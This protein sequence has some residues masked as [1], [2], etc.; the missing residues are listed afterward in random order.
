MTA[1]SSLYS[2]ILLFSVVCVAEVISLS[3]RSPFASNQ[4]DVPERNNVR[5]IGSS[6]SAFSNLQLL[7]IVLIASVD[8]KIRA[9][10][11]GSGQSLW[12]MS[13]PSTTQSAKA[14][15]PLVQTSFPN[16]TAVHGT[17]QEIYIIE[18]QSGDIYVMATPSGQLQ[19]FP[20]S[21]SELVDLS[22]LSIKGEE[23]DRVFIGK[24]STSLLLVEL[25][26]GKIKAT[27]NTEC[28][29]EPYPDSKKVI[30]LDDLEGDTARVRQ[31]TEVFIGRTG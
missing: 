13:A 11:R 9:V 28:P 27:L 25:E 1:I 4:V 5:T 20:Y 14:F 15:N 16:E 12:T 30:D 10:N 17:D 3:R 29:W 2:L 24:K 7:D 31:S 26:T 19:R 21:M 8:G 6:N 18:P 23:E 22:P